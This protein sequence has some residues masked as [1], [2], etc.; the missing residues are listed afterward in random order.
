MKTIKK[1]FNK[2]FPDGL[3]INKNFK[4]VKMYGPCVDELFI[5]F[6]GK[7][8]HY[9]I[10][11]YIEDDYSKIEVVLIKYNGKFKGDYSYQEIAPLLLS[12]ED[13]LAIHNIIEIILNE[14]GDEN[15]I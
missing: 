6:N 4:I 12:D 2:L 13:K 7:H 1:E 14:I 11:S 5:C 10:K 15:W 9:K 8:R 3:K